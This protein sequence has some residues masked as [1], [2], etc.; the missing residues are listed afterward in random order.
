MTRIYLRRGTASDLS[1]VVLATGEA[2]YAT[3]SKV[4]KVG[5]GSNNF[6]TLSGIGGGGGG[7]TAFTALSD[8]PSNFTGGS[9]LFVKVNNG[10][11][12]LEF[13]AGG[14]GGIASV[15]ADTTPQ[16]GGNLDLNS[17]NVYGNGDIV[18]TGTSSGVFPGNVIASGL[19]KTGGTSAQ[20]L[21]AD[22]SVDGTT[23]LSAHPNIS[24]ASSV[25]NSGGG[26]I[27]DITVDSNG[28]I[29]GLASATAV[30]SDT[31]LAGATAASISAILNI[32]T[33]SSGDYAG[34]SSKNANTL[35]FVID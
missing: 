18:L 16:L 11:S 3:D 10:E 14:G 7:A 29:T 2:A 23:Y 19:I 33:I 9:G 1:T 24:A 26:F 4:L 35:Y 5:D 12:A 22:G 34:L 32:V 15:A 6:A 20:F 13:V 31:G 28:H 27:Q 8:T 30:I 25:N 21:K 17:K